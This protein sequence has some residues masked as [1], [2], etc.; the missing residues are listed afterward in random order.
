MQDF[1]KN[2]RGINDGGDLP[3]DYMIALYDRIVN[4]EIKM[5][6]CGTRSYW[7]ASAGCIPPWPL[8]TCLLQEKYRL[9]AHFTLGLDIASLICSCY[10]VYKSG[11][12]K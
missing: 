3:A 6:V 10:L 8:A 9:V 2:N 1:L 5:K 7:P 12:L 11:Q 4:D